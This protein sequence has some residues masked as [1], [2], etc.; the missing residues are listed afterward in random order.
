M[1]GWGAISTQTA[2]TV[3]GRSRRCYRRI[4]SRDLNR[5][6]TAWRSCLAGHRSAEAVLDLTRR[7]GYVDSAIGSVA[8]A[9]SGDVHDQAHVFGFSRY[10]SCSGTSRSRGP[11]ARPRPHPVHWAKTRIVRLM[12]EPVE[13]TEAGGAT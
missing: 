11:P 5:F 13:Q 9:N 10:T 3:A 1:R 8:G 12:K 6:H 2:R 7:R 4:D